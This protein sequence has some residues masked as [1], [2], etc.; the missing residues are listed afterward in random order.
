MLNLMPGGTE[1]LWSGTCPDP[2]RCPRKDAA[3]STTIKGA[4]AWP[5]DAGLGPIKE[6]YCTNSECYYHDQLQGCPIEG[7]ASVC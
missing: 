3:A 6:D 7:D 2:V 5:G 4:A 1:V